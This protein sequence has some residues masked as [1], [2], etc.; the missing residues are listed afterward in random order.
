[1][2]N[3]KATLVKFGTLI[4]IAGLVFLPSRAYAL[5]LSNV[6]GSWS[7]IVE[8]TIG[9]SFA[10]VDNATT[11][12]GNG[13]E[14]Q[15]RW[16]ITDEIWSGVPVVPDP[17]DTQSGLGFTGSAGNGVEVIFGLGDIF[18]IGEL[19]HFNRPIWGGTQVL[20][21][22]LA[23]GFTFSDPAG[24]QQEF[25]LSTAVNE[26]PNVVSDPIS[27]PINDD[28]ITFANVGATEQFS[29]NGVP[30]L[31]ELLG[32]GPNSS[33]IGTDFRSPE[34]MDNASFVFGRITTDP[35]PDDPIPDPI[36]EPS[37]MF[38]LG[39]GLIGIA[40]LGKRFRKR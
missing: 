16:G 17:F 34:G 5:T 23:V 40:T 38:L 29:Y 39:I 37:T 2:K 33:S 14:E 32:F 36:P 15:L 22:T 3:T 27:A 11:T 6:S 25:Q 7:G 28:I 12:Y 4:L 13:N 26:T 1:M 30:Y 8:Q 10:R 35:I 21:A 18:T 31:F 19:R 24:L 9:F 20:E